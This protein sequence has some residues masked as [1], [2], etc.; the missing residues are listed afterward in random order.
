LRF[1][2][3]AG[4]LRFMK[5]KVRQVVERGITFMEREYV[6]LLQ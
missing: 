5:G 1:Y 2:D 3:V 4:E 6:Q